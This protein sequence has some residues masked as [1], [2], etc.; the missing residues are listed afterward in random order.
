VINYLVDFAKKNHVTISF[1][2]NIRLKLWSKEQ[3]VAC[4]YNILVK[5]DI[6][7]INNSEAKMLLNTDDTDTI[8]EK[9]RGFG[10]EKIAVKLGSEGA[11]VADQ[12]KIYRCPK[13][14]TVVVDNIGAGDAFN[15]GF[16]CGVIE[17]KNIEMCGKMGA[18]MGALAVS[19][20]G[21][22]EGLP[23]REQL[24]NYLNHAHQIYR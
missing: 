2:P 19:S 20:Y 23:N 1:D 9:L 4:L 21:D 22:V 24:E 10:A 6:V 17:G 16:L 12:E 11:V 13:I 3:A 5:S 18:M 7:L 15:S 14:K 8:I